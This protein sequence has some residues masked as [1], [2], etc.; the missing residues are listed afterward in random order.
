MSLDRRI[1]ELLG[2]MPAILP[3]R[4]PPCWVRMKTGS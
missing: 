2:V 1:L 4:L 3:S